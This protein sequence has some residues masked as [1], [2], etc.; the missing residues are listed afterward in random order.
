MIFMP[1]LLIESK[2]TLVESRSTGKKT[3]S[4]YLAKYLS[5]SFHLRNLY[6]QHGLN[7]KN[8]TY[9]F[10]KNLY[11]YEEKEAILKNSSKFDALTNQHL[12]PNQHLFRRP[13]N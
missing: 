6:Q 12:A 11:Q 9:R 7:N 4:Q 5:K 13:A 1:L 8:K 3:I 10:F 2:L